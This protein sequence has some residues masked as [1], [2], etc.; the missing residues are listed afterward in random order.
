MFQMWQSKRQANSTKRCRCRP[1]SSQSPPLRLLKGKQ[2]TNNSYVFQ[3]ATPTLPATSRW[4]KQTVVKRS[5]RALSRH[6]HWTPMVLDQTIKSLNQVGSLPSRSILLL[7]WHSWARRIHSLEILLLRKTS[8]QQT[9]TPNLCL[10]PAGRS[11]VGRLGIRRT[12][13]GHSPQSKV[14]RLPSSALQPNL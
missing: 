4:L 7:T 11:P 3:V 5:H 9:Q 10:T 14:T 13:L 6:S 8:R 1:P 12:G 2:R